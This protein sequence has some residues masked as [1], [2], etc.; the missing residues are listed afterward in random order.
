MQMWA[1]RG[2]DV[3]ESRRR[4]V[5][6]SRRRCGRLCVQAKFKQLPIAVALEHY[7]DMNQFDIITLLLLHERAKQKQSL[8]CTPPSLLPTSPLAPS[9]SRRP[10][11]SH[12][13][14]P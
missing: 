11:S 10:L 1:S 2:A 9:P 14:F 5:G 12:L 7:P 4:C 8:W 3:G 13:H 6:E